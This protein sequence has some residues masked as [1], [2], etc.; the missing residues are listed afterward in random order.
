MK[1]TILVIILQLVVCNATVYGQDTRC[2]VRSFSELNASNCDTVDLN[3]Q[4]TFSKS[5]CEPRKKKWQ[6]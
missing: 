2:E 6:M 5:E 4:G 1:P 3:L